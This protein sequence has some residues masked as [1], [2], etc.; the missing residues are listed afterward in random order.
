MQQNKKSVREEEVEGARKR[1]TPCGTTN[2]EK[3]NTTILLRRPCRGS[4]RAHG[5]A[6]KIISVNTAKKHEALPPPFPPPPDLC[7]PLVR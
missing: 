3:L 1:L 7:G 5:F 4:T 6:K 2:F